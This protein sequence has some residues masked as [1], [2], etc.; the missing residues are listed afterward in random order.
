MPVSASG[1]AEPV[2]VETGSEVLEFLWGF[3]HRLFVQFVGG[4]YECFRLGLAILRPIVLLL[5]LYNCLVFFIA[6]EHDV[7]GEGIQLVG[8]RNTRH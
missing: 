8:V 7:P 6:A 3:L 4:A 2:V 1:K 5:A